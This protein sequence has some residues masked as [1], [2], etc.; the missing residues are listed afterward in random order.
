M[1]ALAMNIIAQKKAQRAHG[2][3]PGCLSK[4]KM[5]AIDDI[6]EFSE[7]ESSE[8][9]SERWSEKKIKEIA[10]RIAQKHAAIIAK[11]PLGRVYLGITVNPPIRR[12]KEHVRSGKDFDQWEVEKKVPDAWTLAKLEYHAIAF[13]SKL[14]HYHR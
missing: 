13:L 9:E 4:K 7:S 6:E 10:L 14:I 2:T 1:A 11:N 3:C 5:V 8:D 12:M